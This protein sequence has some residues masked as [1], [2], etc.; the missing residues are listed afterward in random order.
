[1][2]QGSLTDVVDDIITFV[3]AMGTDS[4]AGSPSN[5]DRKAIDWSLPLGGAVPDSTKS[6]GK[7]ATPAFELSD[8]DESTH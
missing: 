5:N 2:L 4:D 7:S 8:T 3:H 1:M 6:T